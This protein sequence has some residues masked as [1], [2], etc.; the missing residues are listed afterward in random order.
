[1]GVVRTFQ[2]IEYNITK[3]RNLQ[4]SDNKNNKSTFHLLEFSIPVIEKIKYLIH[5]QVFTQPNGGPAA[6]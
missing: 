4:S 3:K 1:M 6:Q 5:N 2:G